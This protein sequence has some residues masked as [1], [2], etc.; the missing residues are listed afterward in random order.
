MNVGSVRLLCIEK[1]T[2][3]VLYRYST[4]QYGTVQVLYR[5]C[6]GT[7]RYCTGIVRCSGGRKCRAIVIVMVKAV[8][9]SK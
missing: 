7:V 9:W 2:V 8:G 4:V 3:Q 6:A 1:S 5:Y